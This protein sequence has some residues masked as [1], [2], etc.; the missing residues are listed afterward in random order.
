MTGD[1][2]AAP[3]QGRRV[4]TVQNVARLLV[5]PAAEEK[6]VWAVLADGVA[7]DAFAAMLNIFNFNQGGDGPLQGEVDD[8]QYAYSYD[9]QIVEAWI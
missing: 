5:I 8:T 7:K 6:D 2:G 9:D 1:G 3:R 4:I